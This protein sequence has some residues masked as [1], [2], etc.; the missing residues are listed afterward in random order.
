[1]N[2][3]SMPIGTHTYIMCTDCMLASFDNMYSYKHEPY[4]YSFIALCSLLVKNTSAIVSPCAR[5]SCFCV[6]QLLPVKNYM[7]VGESENPNLISMNDEAQQVMSPSGAQAPHGERASRSTVLNG[8]PAPPPQGR[9]DMDGETMAAVGLN[10]TSNNVELTRT[11]P[12]P[13]ELQGSTDTELPSSSRA[14]M[15]S[16]SARGFLQGPR[17]RAQAHPMEETGAPGQSQMSFLGGVAKAVQSIPAAVEGLVLGHSAPTPPTQDIQSGSTGGFAPAQSGSPERMSGAA[18][19]VPAP[20]TPLLDEHTLQRL[21]GMQ[22]S[23][24]HLYIP[25]A[26]SSGVRPPSTTSSDI[27]AEV[28]RQVREYLVQRDEENRELRMRVELLMSENR[29]LRQ[30]VSSQ[31]YSGNAT[32]RPGGSGRCSGLEWIGRGFGNLMSGVTS[33]KPTSPPKG[34]MDLRPPPPPPS[35]S[36]Q[37]RRWS[38]SG[39]RRPQRASER[40]PRE[41]LS[42][43]T[44]VASHVGILHPKSL[45]S[46]ASE[47]AE[48]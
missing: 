33:P 35:V 12:V 17:L 41:A 14:T 48:S 36:H 45:S 7:A 30:E 18:P 28:R 11:T 29:T 6:E 27:Q 25:E 43:A 39:D 20:T 44:E 34:L 4:M 1:M 38:C 3:D 15:S 31:V 24:P 16:A 19:V 8:I 21:N 9:Q 23:A 5:S 47:R 22:V 42:Q 2:D 10:S 32:A 26:P 46:V 40:A 13:A 37:H